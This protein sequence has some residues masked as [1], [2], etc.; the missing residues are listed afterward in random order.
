MQASIG[1][2]NEERC[3]L[4]VD[5]EFVVKQLL[6]E[7]LNAAG[8][9]CLVAT[10]VEQGWRVLE[11]FAQQVW[12]VI[13][14]M[15]GKYDGIT[16][17]DR[18]VEVAQER[19]IQVIMMSSSQDNI[20]RAVEH[21]CEDF[22]TKPI[23]KQLLLKR[24]AALKALV[25]KE[26]TRKSRENNVCPLSVDTL[27]SFWDETKSYVFPLIALGSGAISKVSEWSFNV[28]EFDDDE[29]LVLTKHMF[30]HFDLLKHCNIE[31]DVLEKFL[32]AVK[33][34]YKNNPYHNW[35]HAFDVT[36][37]T[38]VFLVRFCGNQMTISPVEKFAL[39]VAALCHD[40]GHPGHNNDFLVKTESDLAMLYNNRSILE[41]CHSFLLF[42]LLSTRP[43]LNILANFSKDDIVT[44][45]SILTDCILSTDPGLHN[46]YVSK[47]SGMDIQMLDMPEQKMLVLQCII[48]MADISNV[49]RKWDSSGYRWSC[50]VSQ[51][52]FKQGD[53]LKSC[54]LDV[55]PYLDRNATTIGKN[56]TMFVERVA[57]PLFKELGRL[58]PE[59]EKVVVE[60][61]NV[62]K[63]RWEERAS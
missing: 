38:F 36:Q 54:N 23:V 2:P 35:R 15:P 49:A 48:K 53:T 22:M 13:L 27:L 61:L 4:I 42:R 16:F 44:V 33:Q 51:E 21:G 30:I 8:Y 20:V 3:I 9:K 34:G 45:R 47:L 28:F 46:S 7:W 6:K 25:E 59:F 10:S 18:I 50:L 60:S 62:N 14:E 55:A 11:H 29:L 43:E 12:L 31:C 26:E 17:L 39:L 57:I 32:V 5:D 1:S 24:V 41:N 63:K 37:A 56:S 58:F 19:N 40:L 52:F